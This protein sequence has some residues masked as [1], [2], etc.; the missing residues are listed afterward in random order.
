LKTTLSKLK[1]DLRKR[2]G[3]INS[4]TPIIINEINIY[5]CL[6]Q[7]VGRLLWKPFGKKHEMRPVS[8]QWVEEEN[9]K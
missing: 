4:G 2:R 7:E 9:L 1:I 5:S 3:M 6:F 8:C